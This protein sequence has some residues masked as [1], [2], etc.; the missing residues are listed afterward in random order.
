MTLVNDLPEKLKTALEKFRSFGDASLYGRLKKLEADTMS[1]ILSPDKSA[2]MLQ[3]LERELE[4]TKR[5]PLSRKRAALPRSSIRHN[6]VQQHGESAS[7][8]PFR[9]SRQD[10]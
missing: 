1:G 7:G 9:H 8:R 10:A 5:L 2:E 3:V 4:Q 6:G